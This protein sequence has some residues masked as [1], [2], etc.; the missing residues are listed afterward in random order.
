[1]AV[2]RVGGVYAVGKSTVIEAAKKYTQKDVP[3]L[4]GSIIM[5][6]IL[7]VSL[8]DI[9]FASPEKRNE[10]RKMMYHELAASRNGVRDGHYCVYTEAGY[11]FPFSEKD[12]GVVAVAALIVASPESI[13]ERRMSIA[14][15]RSTDLD[16]IQRQI[17][18]EE[19]A[20]KETAKKLS[21]P[22]ATIDNEDINMAAIELGVLYNTYLD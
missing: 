8:E 9:P 11:E 5:A 22:L 13:L 19:T 20:A 17:E 21:V 3:V 4:K 18:L 14:R 2:I 1:M 16:V 6:R 7:G 12:V 15:T 10:A